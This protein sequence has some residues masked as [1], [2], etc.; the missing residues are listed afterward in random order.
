MSGSMLL[1]MQYLRKGLVVVAKNLQRLLCKIK[2]V[3][4][5]LIIKIPQATPVINA[6]NMLTDPRY[7]G[8][9]N[10]AS[11]PKFFIKLLLMVL[12]RIDQNNSSTWYF[13]K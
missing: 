6:P 2:V 11:A 12:K 9:K 5:Q 1:L 8:A 7:S 4:F 3:M 10:K 13:L